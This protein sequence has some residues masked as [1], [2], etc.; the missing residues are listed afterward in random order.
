MRPFHGATSLW[1]RQRTAG[2]EEELMYRFGRTVLVV[3]VLALATAAAG[4]GGD[5]EGAG[6]GDATT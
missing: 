4:C 1:W 3:I 6:G 5:D 2:R